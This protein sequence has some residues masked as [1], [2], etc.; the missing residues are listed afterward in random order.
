MKRLPSHGSTD[1]H[2]QIYYGLRNQPP[3]TV[4][5]NELQ[6][7]LFFNA[8]HAQHQDKPTVPSPSSLSFEAYVKRENATRHKQLPLSKLLTST[9]STTVRDKTERLPPALRRILNLSDDEEL[10]IEPKVKPNPNVSGL[11]SML[12]ALQFSPDRER[13]FLPPGDYDARLY[14]ELTPDTIKNAQIHFDSDGFEIAET[15][16]ITT[17][18]FELLRNAQVVD[19]ECKDIIHMVHQSAVTTHADQETIILEDD[20]SFSDS[21]ISGFSADTAVKKRRIVRPVVHSCRIGLISHYT[22]GVPYHTGTLRPN[23]TVQLRRRL[24]R[25]VGVHQLS[26][27]KSIRAN[28]SRRFTRRAKMRINTGGLIGICR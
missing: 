23:K 4:P 15:I 20:I 10:R 28:K 26:T 27:M 25:G 17:A 22:Q 21:G 11:E 5:T 24:H 9:N 1:D 2:Q 19:H 8:L 6:R 7:S 3:G 12:F 18:T 16:D 13:E 14:D